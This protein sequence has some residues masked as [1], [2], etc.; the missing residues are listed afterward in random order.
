MLSCGGFLRCLSLRGCKNIVDGTIEEFSRNCPNIHTLDLSDCDRISD[1]ALTSLGKHTKKLKNATFYRYTITY[2]CL[3]NTFETSWFNLSDQN[4]F[5][6]YLSTHQKK[7]YQV[8]YFLCTLVQ[9][10]CGWTNLFVKNGRKIFTTVAWE[11]LQLIACIAE[12]SVLPYV[13]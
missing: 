8:V 13:W 11:N 9:P 12:Y 7:I 1:R 6:T 4:Y 5:N 10:I 2:L 3:I